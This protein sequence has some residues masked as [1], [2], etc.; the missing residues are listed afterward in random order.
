MQKIIFALLSMLSV[1]HSSTGVSVSSSSSDN[2]DYQVTMV[3]KVHNNYYAGGL[4][5][6][7]NSSPIPIKTNTTKTST[8]T[9]GLHVIPQGSINDANQTKYY[10]YK[11]HQGNYL[12]EKENPTEN[13]LDDNFIFYFNYPSAGTLLVSFVDGECMKMVNSDGAL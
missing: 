10:L 6:S 4:L 2:G 7:N 3:N 12:L 11:E 9:W 13:N 5:T 8:Y 1:F